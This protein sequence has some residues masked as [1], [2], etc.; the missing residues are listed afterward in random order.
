MST[1]QA[2][3][4]FLTNA[5]INAIVPGFDRQVAQGQQAHS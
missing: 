5:F 3:G 1:W 4:E 2:L